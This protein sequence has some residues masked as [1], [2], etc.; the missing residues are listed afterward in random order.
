MVVKPTGLEQIDA[1]LD[2]GRASSALALAVEQL[3]PSVFA[4]LRSALGDDELA[5]EAFSMACEDLVRTIAAYR[6]ECSIRTWFFAVA[7]NAARHARMRGQPL[8]ERL[9][10]APELEAAVRTVTAPHQRTDWKDRLRALREKLSADDQL[11]LALRLDSELSWS[12]VARIFFA[13]EVPSVG[14]EPV[15]RKRFER[16]KTLL[17]REAQAAGWLDELKGGQ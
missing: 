7:R 11:L 2:A 5:L 12:E 8:H 17:K 10:N 9:S 15:L 1:E 14:S 13:P 16:I 6:R 4:F 3:G